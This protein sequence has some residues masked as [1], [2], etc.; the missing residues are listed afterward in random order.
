MSGVFLAVLVAVGANASDDDKGREASKA[1]EEGAPGVTTALLDAM[2]ERLAKEGN[3]EGLE[4][5]SGGDLLNALAAF[6][7]AHEVDPRDPSI[8][9]NLGVVQHRL[10]DLERAETFYRLTLRLDPLRHRVWVNLADVLLAGQPDPVKLE[11]LAEGLARARREAR[12]D[13]EVALR[14]ARVAARRQKFTHAE[15]LYRHALAK[16][17]PDDAMRIEL[18]DFYRDFEREEEAVRWYRQ[19]ATDTELADSARDRI[20]RLEVDRQAK[21]FGWTRQSIEVS[22]RAKTLAGKGRT[23]SKQ[24]R[25]R[26]AETALREAVRIAPHYSEARL[27]LGDLLR[28]SDRFDEA[29]VEYLRGLA[30]DQGSADLH[31]RLGELYLER[32]DASRAAEAA[33]L[34]SRALQLRPDWLPVHLSLARAYRASGDL[35]RALASVRRYLAGT[36]RGVDRG[37]AEDLE[38]ALRRALDETAPRIPKPGEPGS[39]VS[40]SRTRELLARLNRARAHLSRGETDAA[41]AELRRIVAEERGAHVRNLEGRI[42]H[43]TGRLEAAALAFRAS[44]ALDQDQSDVHKQ[45]GIVLLALGRQEEARKQFIRAEQ[46]GDL[47]A[48]YHLARVELR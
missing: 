9:F 41:M 18:G 10:G 46:L 45:M 19:V 14:Q 44:L 36:T 5:L 2:M 21:Q 47:E 4:H 7:E 42:L 3:E 43:A 16:R 33:V 6:R 8:T 17:A 30:F 20:W 23:L 27:L 1:A 34:L 15:R 22:A 48:L 31:V 24:G 13:V 25:H 28:E 39:E 29:E 38:A 37:E 12:G 26:D 11:A 40:G 35:P 32:D